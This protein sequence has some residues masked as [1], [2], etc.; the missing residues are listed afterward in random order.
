MPSPHTAVPSSGTGVT[1]GTSREAENERDE[2][3]GAAEHPAA[4]SNM[5]PPRTP[6]P[7]VPST[8]GQGHRLGPL[9]VAPTVGSGLQEALREPPVTHPR[10]SLLW[11]AQPEGPVSTVRPIHG[12]RPCD[13]GLR[14][15]PVTRR[16]VPALSARPPCLKL[17]PWAGCGLWGAR[18]APLAPCAGVLRPFL[19]LQ[20]AAE[21]PAGRGPCRGPVGAAEPALPVSHPAPTLRSQQQALLPSASS[22]SVVMRV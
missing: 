16:P 9:P 7:S 17:R 19:S 8:T 18:G 10:T 14:S 21:Q 22:G 11:P 6:P 13:L 4:A 3:P 2:G 1:A 20:D 5:W 12:T 15:G